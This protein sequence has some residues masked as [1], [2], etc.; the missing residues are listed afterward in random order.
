MELEWIEGRR[1]EVE[2]ELEELD[3]ISGYQDLEEIEEKLVL[4]GFGHPCKG[5][6]EGEE[7]GFARVGR[8]R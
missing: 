3:L 7:G 5:R 6:E 1:K 8:R 4:V 2:N